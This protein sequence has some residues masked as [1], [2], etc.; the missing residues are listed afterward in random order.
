MRKK[1]TL[2]C[3]GAFLMHSL[4]PLFAHDSHK[5][6][7]HWEIPSMDPDRIILTFHGDPSTSRAV[8]WRTDKSIKNAFAQIDVTPLRL[9]FVT[10]MNWKLCHFLMVSHCF[11]HCKH[12]LI[13]FFRCF[14]E[15]PSC[16]KND[17]MVHRTCA[18]LRSP[19][20]ILGMA[21]IA[22]AAIAV[23]SSPTS[24]SGGYSSLHLFS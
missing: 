22:F 20:C 3:L 12:F 9:T 23:M 21:H 16:A 2:I 14:L 15:N 18:F 1:G 5:G 6:L 4:F 24:F 13:L 7:H 19:S 10:S 8:T 11:A 17:R